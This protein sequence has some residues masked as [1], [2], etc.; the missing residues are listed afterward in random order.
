VDPRRSSG[1]GA[2]G[3]GGVNGTGIL[4]QYIGGNGES[5]S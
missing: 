4:A 2:I 1:V 3:L 5:R